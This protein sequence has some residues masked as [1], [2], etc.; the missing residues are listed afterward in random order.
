MEIH[1]LRTHPGVFLRILAVMK[2][3]TVERLICIIPIL[4]TAAF[5]FTLL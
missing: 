2:D 4:L 3:F 5:K 1:V